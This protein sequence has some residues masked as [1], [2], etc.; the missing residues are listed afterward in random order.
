MKNLFKSIRLN[1]NVT[2]V[3]DSIEY[4]IRWELKQV[5]EVLMLYS[6][7][8]LRRSPVKNK[9][10]HIDVYKFISFEIETRVT[11][12]SVKEEK[13]YSPSVR[14]PKG[15]LFKLNRNG[16]F[17]C[18]RMKMVKHCKNGEVSIINNDEVP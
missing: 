6:C 8:Q 9:S 12:Q 5:P 3:V 13:S 15:L 1:H 2:Y 18:N 14:F 16:R 4:H 11:P 10:F 7:G 17:I